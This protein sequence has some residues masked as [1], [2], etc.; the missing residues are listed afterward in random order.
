M[1]SK[2]SP[3]SALIGA[4]IGAAAGVGASKYFD[5]TKDRIEDY[6]D[7]SPKKRSEYRIGIRR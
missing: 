7:L 5:R 3:K 6:K 2:G 1:L 4:G